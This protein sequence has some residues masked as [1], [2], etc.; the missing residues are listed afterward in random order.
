MNILGINCSVSKGLGRVSIVVLNS[1]NE[2]QSYIYKSPSIFSFKE[3]SAEI[4]NWHRDNIISLLNQFNIG[5]IV[6]KKTEQTA[7]YGKP[8][9]RDIFKLYLEGVFL[10][11]AGNLGIFNHHFYKN[12]IQSLLADKDVFDKSIPEICDSYS[13]VNELGEFKEADT[14]LIKETVLASIALKIKAAS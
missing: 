3:N 8:K 10:S 13:L 2:V 4:L 1:E 11:L 12:E 14:E 6:V 9:K 7:F 5:G